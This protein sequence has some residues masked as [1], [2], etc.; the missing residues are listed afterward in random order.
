[1]ST[2]RIPPILVALAALLAIAPAAS[3]GDGRFTGGP[4]LPVT[5]PTDVATGDF[6]NDGLA[7]LAVGDAGDRDVKILR[8]DGESKFA[9][10]PDIDLTRDP[11]SLAIAD[12]NG[13]GKDDV[14]VAGRDSGPNAVVTVPGQGDGTFGA[15]KTSR[16]GPVGLAVGDFNS[17]LQEDLV[18]GGHPAFPNGNFAAGAGG[19]GFGDAEDIKLPQPARDPHGW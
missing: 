3:A 8:G 12:F 5:G 19:G 9:P 1:M 10:M 11:I 4:D 6:N 13:D 16:E 7:D 15:P 18:Y 17:D 2:S 14:V